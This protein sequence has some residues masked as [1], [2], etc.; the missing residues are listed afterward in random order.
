VG[1]SSQ[2]WVGDRRWA[3]LEEATTGSDSKA[4]MG[5]DAMWQ[6][7]G[8]VVPSCNGSYLRATLTETPES[9]SSPEKKVQTTRATRG[10]G[11]GMARYGPHFILFGTV[12]C[13]PPLR[14]TSQEILIR[15]I[16]MHHLKSSVN[17][18]RFIAR[19]HFSK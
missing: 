4:V 11:P 7:H 2:P 6:P 12:L 9:I 18:L 10:R 13:P 19:Y 14:A 15:F 8:E 1:A 16:V 3:G 5:G 17:G